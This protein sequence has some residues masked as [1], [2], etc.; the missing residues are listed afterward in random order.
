MALV[1]N[2]NMILDDELF[3]MIVFLSGRFFHKRRQPAFIVP[4]VYGAMT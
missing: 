4:M 1:E 3:I 2:T